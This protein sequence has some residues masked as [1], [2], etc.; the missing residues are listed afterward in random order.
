[1]LGLRRGDTGQ[2]VRSAMVFLRDAGFPP[3]NSMR[4]DG[5]YDGVYGDGMA[6]AVL[7]CRHFMNS[8]AASGDHISYWAN[9]QIKRAWFLAQL[10]AAGGASSGG[11]GGSL[12][13]SEDITLTGTL[14]RS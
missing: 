6:N 14:K 4:S 1:M 2:R 7:E 13:S 9:N 12:P 10:E 5:E 11:G 3:A 8:G